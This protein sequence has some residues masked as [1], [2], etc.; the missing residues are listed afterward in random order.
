MFTFCVP[1]QIIFFWLNLK[2]ITK[3]SVLEWRSAKTIRRAPDKIGNVNKSI[4]LKTYG[5][6]GI[7]HQIMVLSSFYMY[8]FWG[9]PEII[10][11]TSDK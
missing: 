10:N 2:I 5:C 3:K 6:N 7:L 9:N 1:Q 11:V 4:P 8:F